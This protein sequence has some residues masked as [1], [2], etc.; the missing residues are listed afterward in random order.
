MCC[1]CRTQTMATKR[2]QLAE[3]QRN[4][5]LCVPFCWTCEGQPICA[6]G[7]WVAAGEQRHR[8][9]TA[10]LLPVQGQTN[11]GRARE[12]CGRAGGCQ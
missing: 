10:L 2:M 3:E 8:S 5:P 6:K 4:K 1:T 11:G 12:G 7:A 9:L